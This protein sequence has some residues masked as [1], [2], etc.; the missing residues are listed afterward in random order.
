MSYKV[1]FRLKLL[2]CHHHSFVSILL[3]CSDHSLSTTSRKFYFI[4][5]VSTPKHVV[6]FIQ[7]IQRKERWVPRKG[8]QGELGILCSSTSRTVVCFMKTTGDESVEV[9]KI[10]VVVLSGFEE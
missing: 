7:E 9:V 10:A 2:L 5:L 8:G 4:L 1:K 3:V 6:V